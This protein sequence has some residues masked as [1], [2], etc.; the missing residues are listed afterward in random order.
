MPTSIQTESEMVYLEASMSDWTCSPGE[1]FRPT[2]S[3][4]SLK[5]LK[6]S[7]PNDDEFIFLV[8]NKGLLFSDFEFFKIREYRF[9]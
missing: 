1:A 9:W 3:M 8:K 7:E 4:R 2:L 6:L 5:K